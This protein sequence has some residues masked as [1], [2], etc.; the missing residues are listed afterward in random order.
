[1]KYKRPSKFSYEYSVRSF[2]PEM[3]TLVKYNLIQ[4]IYPF[5]NS[6]ISWIIKIKLLYIHFPYFNYIMNSISISG[7]IGIPKGSQLKDSPK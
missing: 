5:L 1:M 3:L 6:I 7:L 2:L 4:F